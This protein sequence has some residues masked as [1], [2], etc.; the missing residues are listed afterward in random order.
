MH[1]ELIDDV[2][3]F[4]AATESFRASDPLR[5]NVAGSVS[6]AVA[7]GRTTYDIG[8]W[9]VREDDGGVAGHAMRTSPFNMNAPPMPY[10]AA[11]A[12]GNEIYQDIG[13]R[14]VDDFLE[15]RFE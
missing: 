8:W 3:E 2:H 12:T 1:V 6:L 7:T 10:N 5:T 9:I 15:M 4:I 14:L 11:N 13:Y